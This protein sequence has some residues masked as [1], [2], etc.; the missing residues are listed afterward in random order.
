MTNV[1]TVCAFAHE[2]GHATMR[3]TSSIF[4]YINARQER[5]AD[6]WAAHFL[7]DVDEY[8][9]AEA[10]YGTRT[11]WIGQEL[12]VLDR[13]VVAFERSLHRIGD[14]IYVNP[15]MGSGQCNARYSA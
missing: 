1:K 14:T 7:I 15:K 13:L 2:L 10:K 11:D 12:G 5:A 6:E 3:H 4:S 8:R 9:H